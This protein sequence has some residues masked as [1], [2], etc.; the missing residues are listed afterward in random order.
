MTTSSSPAP[1]A[2]PA[3]DRRQRVT[4]P[5]VGMSC[6]ACASR[7]QRQ[8]VATAGV[9]DAAVNFATTKATV[10]FRGV[11]PAALMSAVRDAGY[12]VGTDALTIAVEGL[13]FAPDPA[14]LERALRELPGVVAAAA[15]PAAEYVRITYV[16]GFFD[17]DSV[18]GAV[19]AAGFVLAAPVTAS[20]P[21]ERE[22]RVREREVRELSRKL[23][24]A[25]AVAFLAMLGS[26][27]LMGADATGRA[28][29]LARLLL[30][31]DATLRGALPWLYALQPA[32]IKLAL[33]VLTLPVVGWAGRGFYVSA[34]RG[35]QHRSAD[36]NTLIGVGTGAAMLYSTVAT[37]VPGLF[38]SA[39]LPADVYYEAVSSIIALILL[40]RLLEARAKGRT[41]EAMRRLLGLAP[42][43][44]RV[45]RDGGQLEVPIA[46]VA[47]GDIVMVRPGEKIPVDGVVRGGRTAV[48]ESMLTGESV[49]VAKAVGDEVAG[50]TLNTTG[51]ITVE[52]TRVGR[53]T[54]L[55]QIVRLVEEAQG[56][57]APVQRLADR[58]AGVFVPV[59]IAIAIAAFVL[60]FDLGPSPAPVFATVVFVSVLII[61]C[62]CA[63]GLATPTAIMV[64][65]GRGAERGVLAKGGGAL[66]AAA[67]LDTIVLDKTGTVTEGRPAVTDLLVAPEATARF[68]DR[69]AGEPEAA[70]LQ[71]VAAVE[72]LSEHPL[73]A[74][75]V[76]A[77]RERRIEIPEATR[78]RAREGRG[79]SAEVAGRQVL[80]GSASFLLEQGI[81]V[82]AFSDAVDG[83]AARARTPVLVAVD[84]APAGLLGLADPIKPTAVA[85]VRA[86][87]EMGLRVYLVTGDVR[88]V[89]IA[90]AGEV[91][92]DDVQSGTLPAGKVAFI[93]QLQAEGRRVAMVGDGIN[94]APALAAADVGL[95]IGTGTDVAVETADIALMSGDLRA[96]V[97]ALELARSTLRTIRQNLFWAFAYNVVG[98]PIAAGLLYP[99]AGVL[100]SP[101]FASAAMAFS[102][103][104][105]VSNSLRLRRFTPR[106]AT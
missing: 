7:I 90:V 14:R 80:V 43:S 71:I 17:P 104:F 22:R 81:D 1:A 50:A 89:A 61:A 74:A 47:V 78:F 93:K 33:F 59:V 23:A 73:A 100:L 54:A 91:G 75:I 72:N 37:F 92:I 105:V 40:G 62:P 20:D 98:I 4:F 55:A 44:A 11:P 2:P 26:M 86:L 66:E 94:D 25:A 88:K 101:V 85:A 102:S 69:P 65:T 83:L 41:S 84:G 5:L 32:A 49:P 87:K 21:V 35:F 99:L 19:T 8:L 58:I 57:R 82:G 45:L 16:P 76:R 53:D 29:L 70:L 3:A 15:N 13:R 36:M 79:A 30:P 77:A 39:G 34:W 48:D 12:D 27:P 46:E 63:M 64:G 38:V 42:R 51:A 28:D 31:L 6:A 52:A 24:L 18:A 106:F 56:S 60:W 68:A 96:A 9:E 67:S 103:V 95:A 97:T 10:E